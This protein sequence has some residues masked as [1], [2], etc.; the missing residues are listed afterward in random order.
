MP[1]GTRWNHTRRPLPSTIIGP[2]W[3]ARRLGA[4]KMSPGAC[5]PV[6]LTTVTPGGCMPG[7]ER[8]LSPGGGLAG[9]SSPPRIRMSAT[10]TPA[11]TS[12]ASTP[13]TIR[14]CRRYGY[15]GLRRG[16]AG[17]G[18]A[19]GSVARRVR[20]VLVVVVGRIRVE[21]D[22]ADGARRAEAGQRP[23]RRRD[24][25]GEQLARLLRMDGAH[26]V[27]VVPVAVGVV[28]ALV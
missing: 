20:A 16:S 10:A 28:D 13:S 21:F 24:G 14:R 12:R 26:L 5:R 8:K 17:A 6:D 18:A 9:S 2:A 1:L 23:A 3:G 7:S 25:L 22:R 27:Q 11:A 4:R 15:R 19:N